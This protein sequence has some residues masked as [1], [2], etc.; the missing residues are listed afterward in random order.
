MTDLRKLQMVELDILKEFINICQAHN[1]KYFVI[2]GTALG[3]VRH[4]GFI[5]WDDD[6]DVSMPRDDYEKFYEIVSNNKNSIYEI[7]AIHNHEN[8][9]AP[10]MK[11]VDKNVTMVIDR[12]KKEI[13]CSAFIDIFTCD[14]LPDNKVIRFFHVYLFLIN[15]FFHV[16]SIFDESI[17]LSKK[18]RSVFER[19]VI[20]LCINF[21]FQMLFNKKKRV[22]KGDRLLKK[23][24][25]GKT[26]YCTTELWG[27]YMTR[28]IFPTDWIGD[29]VLM[30]FENIQVRVPLNYKNYLAQLYGDNY[31]TLPPEENRKTHASSFFFHDGG[32]L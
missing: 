9:C 2:A 11:L 1:L 18:N 26:N 10:C 21:N 20:W 19:L 30:P 23:Y 32:S 27:H 5:P 22:I 15:K 29:G 4:N 3:A 17:D 7:E 31:M 14:G 6:I 8:H 28:T 25:F 13:R 24:K 12:T 16:I